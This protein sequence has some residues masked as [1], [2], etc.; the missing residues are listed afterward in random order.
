[1]ANFEYFVAYEDENG[2]EIK[3]KVTLLDGPSQPIACQPPYKRLKIRNFRT[4]V[5]SPDGEEVDLPALALE[6]R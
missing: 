5:L 3:T 2:R 6:P 4:F 1:M